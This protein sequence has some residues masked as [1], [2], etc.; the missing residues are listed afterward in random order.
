M[1]PGGW[2]STTDGDLVPVRMR[3]AP[4]GPRRSGGQEGPVPAVLRHRDGPGP[5]RRRRRRGDG[6]GRARTAPREV[7]GRAD[8][9]NL[10]G[11]GAGPDRVGPDARSAE[12]PE[13]D[14]PGPGRRRVGREA[15]RGFVAPGVFVP[16][17]GLGADPAHVLA[18]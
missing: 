10:P 2:G 14:G 11:R 7:R 5:R 1:R 12:A 16:A 15:P 18:P 17:P 8:V 13:G 6:P 3:Q 9:L 4:P